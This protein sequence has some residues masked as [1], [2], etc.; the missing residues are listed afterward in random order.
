[1]RHRKLR[2]RLSRP[3]GHRRA[4]LRN[5]LISLLRHQRIKTTR[6]KARVLQSRL[7]QLIS[8]SK[9]N[10]LLAH[11]QAFK[12]LNSRAAVMDLF[13]RISPLFKNRVSGFSRII[14]LSGARRGDGAE[15]VLIEL[16]EKLT[17]EKPAKTKKTE[18]AKPEVKPEEKAK[19]IKERPPK[20]VKPKKFLGGLRRL[21]KRERDSL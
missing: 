20:K 16:T 17:E 14:R 18:K 10:N 6:A 4:L 21:F 1:M 5:Q 13:S 3:A 12:A 9:P 2:Q 8:L 11:R 19:P 7:E 15:L